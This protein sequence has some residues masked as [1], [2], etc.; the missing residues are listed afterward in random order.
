LP[1]RRDLSK[2][3]GVSR[4]GTVMGTWRRSAPIRDAV[5]LGCA[6]AMIVAGPVR[7]AD[8]APPT[9]QPS[10]TAPADTDVTGSSNA[11]KPPI[12]LPHM[13]GF[14]SVIIFDPC[15]SPNPPDDCAITK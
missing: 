15:K 4:W 13:P 8:P 5:L 7:A 3:A 1:D 10:T 2:V 14:D 12:V 6:L 11:P 9:A